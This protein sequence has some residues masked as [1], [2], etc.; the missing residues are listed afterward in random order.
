M[1]VSSLSGSILDSLLYAGIY[2]I[3]INEIWKPVVGYESLYE[4]SNFG[5]IKALSKVILCRNWGHIVQKNR[6]ERIVKGHRTSTGYLRASLSIGDGSDREFAIHRLV[7]IAFIP[8]PENKKEVNHLNGIKDD[9]RVENLEWATPL[10]NTRHAWSTGLITSL[11]GEAHPRTTLTNEEVISIYSSAKVSNYRLAKIH[12][13]SASTIANIKASRT[14]QH[15]TSKLQ[16]N[17]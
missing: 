3:M 10:E 2:I 17:G 11:T 9:N 8:N 5:K 1:Q 13:V 12:K 6:K 14:W 4:V 16:F 7:A 15:L